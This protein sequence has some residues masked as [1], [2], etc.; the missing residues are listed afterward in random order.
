MKNIF[1]AV[2]ALFLTYF[3]SGQTL[4]NLDAATH[5]TT[6]NG[7]S[8]WFYD[9]GTES[10]DY[11]SGQNRWITFASTSATSTHISISFSSFDIHTGDTLFIYDGPNT[12][13]P[14]IGA[15]NNSNPL[16]GAASMIQSSVTNASGD[17]TIQFKSN[18][19]INA[20]GWVAAI[21]CIPQ[22]QRIVAAID[23]LAMWPLP[24]SENYI[25]ICAGDVI[26]F[27]AN[28][29]DEIFPENDFVYHQDSLT[30]TFVWDFGDGTIDTG[31]IINHSYA[32]PYGYNVTLTVYDAMGCQSTELLI[33]RVRISYNPIV[34]IKPLPDICVGDSIS[35]SAGE[36][37][38]STIVVNPAGAAQSATQVYDSTTFIPDGPDCAETCYDTPVTFNSFPP[39]TTI[40]SATDIESICIN[41]EHSW[42]GDLSF[43]IICPNGNFVV[44]D[45]YVEE[46]SAYMGVPNHTDSYDDPCIAASNPPGTG[47]LY[48]WSEIYPTQG[49]LGELADS[50]FSTIPATDTVNDVDYFD[51]EASLSGLI[52]CPLNGTWNIQ[53]CDNWGIDNGYIFGWEMTLLNQLPSITWNYSVGIDSLTWSGPNI[54][55]TSDSTALIQG[56]AAG[57]FTYTATVWDVFGCSYD[58]TF[59]VDVIANPE[60]DLGPD[61]TACEGT[62]ITLDAGSG[63]QFFW[64]NG[65]VTQTTTV[66]QSGIYFVYVTNTNGSIGCTG[67]DTIEVEMIPYAIVNLGPDLCETESVTLDAQNPGFDYQWSNGATT[68]TTDVSSSGNY[69]VTVSYSGSSQCANSDEI[70]VDIIPSPVVNLGPDQII[71]KHE[72]RDFDVAQTSPEYS[73]LWSTSSTSPYLHVEGLPIGTYFY[74][75]TVTGCDSKSDTIQVD[76]I[77]CDLTIPNIITPNSD[78]L[79]DVFKVEN[80]SFYPNSVLIVFNRWGKKIYENANYLN[81]WDGENFADGTYYYILRV[82]YG[83]E[84]Y[85]DHHGTLTIMRD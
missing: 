63:S 57:T 8:F 36:N 68:Q 56:L 15:Y 29:R 32:I 25:D 43:K 6:Q 12:S 9:D 37:A 83:D 24:D 51:P 58:T 23:S 47:W 39:G 79:N 13:S 7:C 78:N 84:E 72:F 21:S 54:T 67:S 16:T 34:D 20:D 69:S 40:S 42:S 48:C 5:N 60:P 71:C 50:T 31:R 11:T 46:G 52:G 3:V 41:M 10:G 81:D 49:T 66:E 18:G 33:L 38:L 22:C 75:V 14:L 70:H 77:V 26:T 30:T 61:T 19:S 55:A 44:L 27:A 4:I 53:I 74:S 1:L 73:Y 76:V 28:N 59:S 45:P 80:L 64:S 62:P 17:L 35:V 2:V 85:E 82:N 65:Q